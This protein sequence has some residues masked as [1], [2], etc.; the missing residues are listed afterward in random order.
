MAPVT[1]SIDVEMYSAAHKIRKSIKYMDGVNEVL[2]LE[3]GRVVVTGN[4][5]AEALKER[6]ESRLRT[7]VTIVSPRPADDDD[8]D[9]DDDAES[10]TWTGARRIHEPPSL[11]PVPPFPD[12]SAMPS[13]PPYV[14][15][16]APPPEEA[17]ARHSTPTT[18][19][20]YSHPVYAGSGWGESDPYQNVPDDVTAYLNDDNANSCSIM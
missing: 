18:E 4:P 19:V 8:D 6:L 1:L 20:T 17:P 5:D 2:F 7:S 14:W 10:S 13:Y 3:N 12:Y 16:G 11:Q 15:Y 9:D